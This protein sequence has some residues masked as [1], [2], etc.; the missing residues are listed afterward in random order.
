MDD[1]LE[2]MDFIFK[3][4]GVVFVLL[5]LLGGYWYKSSVG[6]NVKKDAKNF[7]VKQLELWKKG[8]YVYL[9]RII[10]E[11]FDGDDSDW[12]ALKLT[13]YYINKIDY[14]T[15]YVRRRRGINRF[16]SFFERNSYGN[17]YIIIEV[18]LNME[19][20]D[21]YPQ[22]YKITYKL[23]PRRR[24]LFSITKYKPLF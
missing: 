3:V 24:D 8:Q 23:E 22:S 21:G 9:S 19:D 4:A 12:K 17:F 13:D 7:L 16:F 2:N 14:D 5:V 10:S 6:S 1:Y 18:E 20:E 11:D 15:H